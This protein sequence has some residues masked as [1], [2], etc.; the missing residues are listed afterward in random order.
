MLPVSLQRSPT[1]AYFPIYFLSISPTGIYYYESEADFHSLHSRQPW[2]KIG[3]KKKRRVWLKTQ[4]LESLMGKRN[5]NA[6]KEKWQLFNIILTSH[7]HI[8]FKLYLSKLKRT[9]AERR[10][11]A[12]TPKKVFSPLQITNDIILSLPFLHMSP[13]NT[14]AQLFGEMKLYVY[15]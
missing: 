12:C 8:I 5:E 7:S 9:R 15:L 3:R 10:C 13:S 6:Y 1:Y 11:G 14:H 4:K 2:E